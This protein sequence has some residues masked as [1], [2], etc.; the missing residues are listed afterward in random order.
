[1]Q[2]TGAEDQ[3]RTGD[4]QIFSLLLYRLSYLGAQVIVAIYLRGVKHDIRNCFSNLFSCPSSLDRGLVSNV[5]LRSEATKNLSVGLVVNQ[6][7]SPP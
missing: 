7:S 6:S 3:N 5:M 2:V 4:T 1:M